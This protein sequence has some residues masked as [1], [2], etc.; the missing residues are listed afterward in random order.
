MNEQLSLFNSVGDGKNCSTTD[1]VVEQKRQAI[2]RYLDKAQSQPTA[3]VG[4]YT[5]GNRNRKYYRLLYR[6]GNKIKTI[7]ICGG[8][9]NS[10]LAQDRARL[11]QQ[12]IDRGTELDV[13]IAA[14]K[15]FNSG[16]K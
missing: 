1:N 9:I 7:H 4:T 6:I 2:Q 11:L 3:S 14:V 10:K 8:N 12:M 16:K 5:P 13:L 15:T